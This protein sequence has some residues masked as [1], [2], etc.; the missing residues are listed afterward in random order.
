MM[1]EIQMKILKT[2][3]T[4]Q[5]LWAIP[6]FA[7][8]LSSCTNSQ[9]NSLL[10]KAKSKL[11][12]KK[13]A[14]TTLGVTFKIT[15]TTVNVAGGSSSTTSTS[16]SPT[17]GSS[18][19]STQAQTVSLFFDAT[20]SAESIASVCNTSTSSSKEPRGCNCKFTWREVNQTTGT[21]ISIPRTVQTQVLAVNPY[22]VTCNLPSIF[23]KEITANTEIKV[24]VMPAS[25]NASKFN[26]P[27]F[28][29]YKKGASETGSFQDIEGRSFNNISRY[30]C[31]EQ[32]TRK[33]N[34]TSF[35]KTETNT[36]SGNGETK[37][38]V[39]ATKFCTSDGTEGCSG[40]GPERISSQAYYYNL[41]I[42]STAAGNLNASNERYK[43]PMV[44]ETLFGSGSVG[45]SKAYWPLDSSFA[46]AMSPGDDY[47]VGVE[48][49]SKLAIGGD[50]ATQGSSC[51][52]AASSG[53]PG[54]DSLIKSC[55]GFAAKPNTDQTCPLIKAPDGTVRRTF[56]LRRF[57]SIYPPL[58]DNA[59]KLINQPQATDTIYVL[60]REVYSASADPYKPYTMRGPKPCPF[61]YFDQQGVLSDPAEADYNFKMPSYAATNY[62]GWNGTNVD[63]IQFPNL[64]VAEKSCAAA[65]PMLSSDKGR[66]S[67][68]TLHKD[69]PVLK[70]LY[71][72]PVKAWAPH[73]EE[74][75]EFQ[76]CAPQSSE[77]KD[78]PLHFAKD[79]STGNVAWCAEAYPTQ[80]PMVASLD[81]RLN[82]TG[83][84]IGRV[85]PFTSHVVKNST[86]PTCSNT[87]IDLSAI[88][89][90][91]ANPSSGTCPGDAAAPYKT[92]DGVA[93]HPNSQAVDD[94]PNNTGTV[95]CNNGGVLTGATCYYCSQR[96]CDRTVIEANPSTYNY[97]LL[98]RAAQV[99]AALMS[100]STYGCTVSYDNSGSKTGKYSP[101]E[102]CC[103]SSVKLWTGFTPITNE[104]Y[105]N[106][107]A[108]LEPNTPCFVPNY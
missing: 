30:S 52:G 76:A 50:P 42:R 97:P 71:V 81:K 82:N 56:R 6:A 106:T 85:M 68:G 43:C 91:P 25:S 58:Y 108:H 75:T 11:D 27:A 18:S 5:F 80:N 14:E 40:I 48:A 70:Q 34:L 65:I 35:K 100:D 102:G 89:G 22:S 7:V 84:Y 51:Y 78:P 57:V 38:V 90:Y 16:P 3:L 94:A 46:L 95:N 53:E 2:N 103:G 93:H 105:T 4:S 96:T 47:T 23:A 31:Y 66:W 45:S 15:S 32:F 62:S 74:D 26:V 37:S 39:L 59:G 67:I 49:F 77:F 87:E 86:S 64:D 19:S 73:Y 99:E 55:L 44:K 28:S 1:R 60:D 41:Y 21:A 33:I 101:K 20:K 92:F 79:P 69:N 9:V 88:T 72:R 24:T 29:F 13:T 8:V 61:A 104:K 12:E 83:N 107:T 10:D 54:T 36:G 17:P 63:G 98:A